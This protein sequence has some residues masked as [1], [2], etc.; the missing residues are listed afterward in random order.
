[1]IKNIT[2]LLFDQRNKYIVNIENAKQ[3][4]LIKLHS[5][6]FYD[7]LIHITPFVLRQMLN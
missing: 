5:R 2:R 4:I 7:I 6:V 1:M 3:A